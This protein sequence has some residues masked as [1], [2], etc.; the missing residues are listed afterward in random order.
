MYKLNQYGEMDVL[1]TFPFRGQGFRVYPT[2]SF[3]KDLAMACGYIDRAVQEFHAQVRIII[4]F[5]NKKF[6]YIIYIFSF[7][8][9]IWLAGP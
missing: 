4:L 5:K 2:V 1:R 8:T 6:L 9:G 3:A 7:L